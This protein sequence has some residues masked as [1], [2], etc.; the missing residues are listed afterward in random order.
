M[1]KHLGTGDAIQEN[2]ENTAQLLAQAPVFKNFFLEKLGSEESKMI[3]PN[4]KKFENMIANGGCDRF[5]M[6]Y[7]QRLKDMDNEKEQQAPSHEKKLEKQT[8]APVK[9]STGL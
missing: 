6:E 4:L 7:L 1:E 3:C 9:G 8:T 5:R 2:I